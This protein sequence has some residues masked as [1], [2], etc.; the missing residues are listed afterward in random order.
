MTEDDKRQQK[1]MLLLEHLEA[2][3]NLAHLQTKATKLAEALGLVREWLVNAS[4]D[5]TT[6][7]RTRL[8]VTIRSNPTQYSEAL[9]FDS[10]AALVD[11]I[12]QAE[13][14]L[15]ELGQSKERLGL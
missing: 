11:E 5:H 1:A 14:K 12:R 6:S 4:R 2:K 9:N 10:V 8:D 3:Q 13:D 7:D 15:R